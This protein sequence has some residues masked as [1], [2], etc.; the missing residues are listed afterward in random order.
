[1]A[2]DDTI[3]TPEDKAAMQKDIDDAKKD[4]VSDDTSKAIEKAKVDAKAEAEK[5]FATNAKIKELEDA[6]K[7]LLDEQTEKEKKSAEQ[8][9]ALTK[10]VDDMTT[11]KANI[12]QQDPFQA[13]PQPDM[14]SKIDSISDEGAL[15]LQEKAAEQFFGKEGYAMIQRDKSQLINL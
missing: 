6:N 8:L 15:D 10:K 13:T 3:L 9:D 11:S 14:K 12:N 1:M 2:D 7:K 5:E 4:L